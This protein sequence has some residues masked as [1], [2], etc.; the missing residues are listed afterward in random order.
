MDCVLPL[1]AP[2]SPSLKHGWGIPGPA[3]WS[4][5]A[6]VAEQPKA[7]AATVFAEQRHG[8]SW[9]DQAFPGGADD[10]L[11]TCSHPKLVARIIDMEIDGTF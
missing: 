3:A 7:L 9:I 10:C 11:N 2:A 6:P 5:A 4:D 8:V 1:I